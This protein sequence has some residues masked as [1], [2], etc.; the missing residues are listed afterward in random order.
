MVPVVHTSIANTRI[1][2]RL[3][4]CNR[5]GLLVPQTTTDQELQHLRNALP[6]SVAVQRVEERLS[7]LGN[8]IVCNDYAAL[9]HPDLDRETE[10]IIQDVLRVEV[11]RQTVADNALVG[12]Y[13]ALSNQGGLVHPRVAVADQD[14]LSSLLQVPLVVRRRRAPPADTA[15]VTD[16]APCDAGRNGQSRQWRHWGWY[17][18]ERLVRVLR[19]RHDQHRTVRHREHLPASRRAAQRSG[20]RDARFSRGRIRARAGLRSR[21]GE[22]GD[23]GLAR[24]QVTDTL[25]MQ[26]CLDGCALSGGRGRGAASHGD[27][28]SQLGRQSVN[29]TVGTRTAQPAQTGARR[30]HHMTIAGSGMLSV[31][32]LCGR[33]RPPFT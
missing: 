12:S 22:G 14:E 17:G 3:V 21:R 10:E 30:T 29:C 4:A 25:A 32:S 18:C 26:D 1:I 13:C 31:I 33:M 24:R 9:V 2:G 20:E 16:C 27:G 28:V 19:T 7:A 23:S 8:V 11:F 6:D 15:T 5:H